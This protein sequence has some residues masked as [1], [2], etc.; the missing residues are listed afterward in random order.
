MYETLTVEDIKNSI[1]SRMVTDID[2]REGSFTNDMIS[3]VAY[4]IWNGYQSLDTI[5]PI[6]Y[7]DESSG[8][9][10]DKRCAE[11]GIKRKEGTKAKVNLAITGTN[12][13]I[14]PKDKVFL[15]SDGLE[16]VTN[17][18]VTITDG[19]AKITA[20]A[21]EIGEAYNVEAGIV[22]RQF[23]NMSGLT[24]VTNVAATGGSDQETDTALVKRL[25]NY[26]QKPAS[27]G[28]ANHYKQWALEVDGVGDAK[29]NPLWNGPG[30]VRIQ[31][32]GNNKEPVDATI[33]AKCMDYIEEK[34]PVGASVT[35]TSAE[36]LDI[37]VEASI[38]INNSTTIAKVQEAFKKVL[39]NYLNKIAFETYTVVYNRIAYM[40]LDIDGVNDYAS[41]KI[42]GGTSNIVVGEEQVPIIGSVV[43]S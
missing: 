41:L 20:T 7:V 2:V 19:T 12:G 43:I 21:A 40:L 8:K 1:L 6:A 37:D 35:V 3:A 26:L 9:Y 36:R 13:T 10:I 34:R 28:N 38:T 39:D 15:T 32:V 17:E 33:I 22:T 11:Y 31:I 29:V 4:E 30:T 23:V 42:N 14:I 5:V 18:T 25:Y 16:F 24:S 27:S